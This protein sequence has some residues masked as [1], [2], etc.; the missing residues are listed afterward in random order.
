MLL[1][2]LLPMFPPMLLP[3]T[4]CSSQHIPDGQHVGDSTSCRGHRFRPSYAEIEQ[5]DTPRHCR[6]PELQL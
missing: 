2:M 6:Y 4:L 5:S 3:L 1:P